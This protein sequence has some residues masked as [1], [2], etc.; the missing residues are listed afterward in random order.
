MRIDQAHTLIDEGDLSSTR[1][2]RRARQDVLG[3]VED[4]VW[5]PDNDEFVVYP[6][7]NA[8]GVNPIT[9]QF[10]PNLDALP[11]WEET[12]RTHLTTLLDRRGMLERTIEKVRPYFHDPQSFLN[13]P[14]FDGLKDVEIDGEPG[15][16]V[17][18]WET[19]NI[20]SSHRSVNRIM[21]G[22]VAGMIHGGFIVLPNRSL[23]HYLTD[24][25]GN[26]RELRP[27]FVIWES[28]AHKVENGVIEVIVVE[29]EGE[30]KAVRPI[31]KLTDGM[32]DRE[33]RGIDE[34]VDWE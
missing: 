1:V 13:S 3:A 18:E 5:P 15:L 28:L 20:S 4:V 30:S 10:E 33:E 8:N 11:D 6:E 32:S 17:A 23:Y 22:L 7:E 21:V 14:W 25:I 9:E 34:R 19:G 12:G 26:Y 24:R 2:W 16:I 31:G 29:H 27:Y